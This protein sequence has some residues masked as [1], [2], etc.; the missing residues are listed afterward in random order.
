MICDHILMGIWKGLLHAAKHEK[1]SLLFF[2]E[3]GHPLRELI[4]KKIAATEKTAAAMK[5][6]LDGAPA[7]TVVSGFD[8]MIDVLNTIAPKVSGRDLD[9][10][11]EERAG[12]ISLKE[13][14]RHLDEILTEPSGE[15]DEPV[16]TKHLN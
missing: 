15:D 6:V 11:Y 16:D 14:F 1:V 9:L 5:A 2:Y 3:E 4:I 13:K 12:L 10:I 7:V 8:E